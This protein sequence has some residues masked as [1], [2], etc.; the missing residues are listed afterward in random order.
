M[1]KLRGAAWRRV[2]SSILIGLGGLALWP[3]PADAGERITFSSPRQESD[4]PAR[5]DI[6]GNLPKP[7]L[8]WDLRGP[9]EDTAPPISMP[10]DPL[11]LK[12][13]RERQEEQRNW[14]LN[15][16][17]LFRDRFPDPFKKT[18]AAPDD[19]LSAW[20]QTANRVF[21]K[22][23]RK[24]DEK[25]TEDK[26]LP[27]A[28][29][30]E[31]LADRNKKMVDRPGALTAG[32]R[33][34]RDQ[35][36]DRNRNRDRDG[37]GNSPEAAMKVLF[38]PPE[39]TDNLT[40][41]PGMPMNDAIDLGEAKALKRELQQKREE[42]QRLLAPPGQIPTGGPLDP[43]NSLVDQTRTPAY[44]VAPVINGGIPAGRNPLELGSA[45]LENRL[46]RPGQFQEELPGSR[47][48]PASQALPDSKNRQLESLNLMSRPSVLSL[49]GRQF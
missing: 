28:F 1:T 42:F 34:S 12:K 25:N 9:T 26:S 15:E 27:P 17:A 39:A 18:K 38:G 37:R 49:P 31:P 19:G 33:E 8:K 44:P 16:P 48:A 3:R 14:L 7:S 40:L 41:L 29:A 36:R 45:P 43:I 20:D 4:V 32:S 13:Q 5:K 2:S 23:E 24:D 11:M 46:A 35:D 10:M 21:G 30:D 22:P 6:P 47:Q